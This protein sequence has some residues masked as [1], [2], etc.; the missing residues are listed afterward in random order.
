MSQHTTT[1]AVDSAEPA[2][3]AVAPA[4]EVPVEDVD[5]LVV[6][7]GKAGKSLAMLRAKAGDAVVMVEKD[8]VGGTCINVACIPTKTLISSARVLH[9]VQG[10]RAHGVTLPEQDG[11]APALERAHIDLAAL[12]ARKEGVVGAMVAAH[13]K[14]FPASGMDFVKGT[15]RFIA[16]R[17]VEIALNDGTTRRVRGAKVLINTGTAPSAP[18]I[19]GLAEAPHWTSEDLLALPELPT[20]LVVLG[21]GVIGVEM[22]SLMGLLGVPVTI[23]HAGGHILDREDDDVAAEVASGLEALGVTILTG[24]RASRVSPTPGGGVVVSTQDGREASGSH[25][26]VAL[27]RT[28]VTAGLGLETAGV[29]LTERGFVKVDDHLRTTAEGVYAA[30]DVAGTPQFTHASWN[31]FRVLR[32]LFA[33]KEAST[34]GRLIPWA[35]FTTPELGHVGLTE[36]EA[37]AAGHEVRVAKTPTAAVPRAKTLGRTE[38][39][40]KIVIDADSDLILG[41]AIIGPEASEVVT[42]VQMAMLGGLTW[43]QV[44][45]AVITHPTMGE[46][47]NIVLDSLG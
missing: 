1:H 3:G 43:Q 32:D 5:L 38:G 12:R 14:M 9:D 37:R 31:D 29:E 2:G 11:G 6:G 47:L 42:G 24:A 39:F 28:P 44:R 13:E 20:S 10:S 8:K 35:V 41:A 40:Y 16:E 33:G 30:G 36:A 17:T 27:G 7:G 23:V 26:L 34:A 18:A 22:A 25:V 19:E 46:G 15:A 21:G 4:Q 45:D